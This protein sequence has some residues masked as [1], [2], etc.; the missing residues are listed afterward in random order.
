ME[1]NCPYCADQPGRE[2]AILDTDIW[3]VVHGPPEATRAGGVK[4]MSRRHFTDFAEM[5]PPEQASFGP[6][7]NSLDLAIRE[8]TGAERVHLVSTRDRVP[9]FHAWLYPRYATDRLRGT[10][11]L[12]APQA[13]SPA[14]AAEAS[15]RLRLALTK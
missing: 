15:D 14:S 10:A 7:L 6:L 1:A 4:I 3:R 11:F 12:D 2:L 9:H 8:V 5:T 13:S